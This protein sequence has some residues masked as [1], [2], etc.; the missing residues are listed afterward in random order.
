MKKLMIAMSA[1]AMFSLCAT[2]DDTKVSGT[3]FDSY[4]LGEATEVALDFGK[5][6]EGNSSGVKYWSGDSE[7]SESMIV[8]GDADKGNTTQFLK[9][10]ESSVLTRAMDIDEHGD[11]APTTIP[12][13][14][15]VYI[16]TKVQ[17]T[18]ADEAPEAE[19][20]DKLLVWLR[21]NEDENATTTLMI[22]SAD[23]D[24]GK[25]IE[26]EA[27]IAVNTTDWY[28]LEIRTTKENAGVGDEA[29]F[30]V[31][32]NG[33]LINEGQQ[34]ISLVA[35]DKNNAATIASLGFKGTGAV[36]DIEF[37]TYTE[38]VLGEFT[39]NLTVDGT[40][41]A[42]ITTEFVSSTN[43]VVKTETI[44]IYV[45]GAADDVTYVITDAEG[46]TVTIEGVMKEDMPEEDVDLGGYVRI[47]IPTANVAKDAVLNVAVTVTGGG[48]EPEEKTYP[49][50]IDEA[51]QA[52]YDA[53]VKKCDLPD[54]VAY[55]TSNE[56]Q[57]AFLLNVVPA[58]LS[59]A[60]AAF[61]ITAITIDANGKV[62]VTVVDKNVN[63]EA[64]NGTVEVKGSATVNGT[65][66]LSVDNADARFFKAIL[67]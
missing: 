53:W 26:T 19:T 38:E 59:D 64:F 36:D 46:A 2:A 41:D 50:Y 47:T 63:D 15:G 13:N 12:D 52:K 35:G 33:K 62:T 32:I 7:N 58:E 45:A 37:G 21:Q 40:D 27:D 48:D 17:F 51:S 65:F 5:D 16:K 44:D 1:A 8:A 49:S 11:V 30:T 39:V 56:Y 54:D 25:A 9:V 42:G 24:T 4:P 60:K 43:F 29:R 66:E 67:K 22:T 10:E 18:A 57:D 28:E 34:F 31:A 23:A 20:G 6:D 3:N 61:K 55:V 14:G